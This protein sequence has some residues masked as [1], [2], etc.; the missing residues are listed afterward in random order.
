MKIGVGVLVALVT[1][2][3]IGLNTVTLCVVLVSVLA[4]F[5]GMTLTVPI[6][7]AVLHTGSFGGFL[8]AMMLL[9]VLSGMANGSVFRMVPH[10]AR[11]AATWRRST[12][13]TSA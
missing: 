1:W 11:K 7:L 12:T 6:V 2:L 4:A 10:C 9:F 8:G 5:A 13:S 3:D